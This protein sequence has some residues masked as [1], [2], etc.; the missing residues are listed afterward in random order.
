MMTGALLL[1]AAFSISADRLPSIVVG[2]GMSSFVARA[3]DD[4]A[5]DVEKIFGK[6][7]EV[8]SAAMDANAIVLAKGGSGDM[9]RKNVVSCWR[10]AGGT[11]P[12]VYG[13]VSGALT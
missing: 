10:R 8:V 1:A 7:L 3:A 12:L 2:P 5:G 13:T 6:R 4:L 9:R 11:V